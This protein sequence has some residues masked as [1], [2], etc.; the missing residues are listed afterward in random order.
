MIK[1]R[2]WGSVGVKVAASCHHGTGS[3]FMQ[4]GEIALARTKEWAVKQGR[5]HR[6]PSLPTEGGFFHRKVTEGTSFWLVP[7]KGTD[8][9]GRLMPTA[10]SVSLRRTDQPFASGTATKRD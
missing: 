8:G 1:R 7:G 2:I 9:G 6:P 4:G 3:A 10:L 5:L